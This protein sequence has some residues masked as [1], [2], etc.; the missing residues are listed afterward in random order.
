MAPLGHRLEH[1][2]LDVLEREQVRRAPQVERQRALREAAEPALERADVRVVD[3]AV[4]DVGDGVARR[5][6]GAA[7]RPPAATAATSGPRAENS[8]VIS[9]SPTSWPSSTPSSTSPTGPCQPRRPDAGTSVDGLDAARRSTRPCCDGRSAR[10]RRR[11]RP[12][13]RPRSARGR[14]RRDRR[15]RGPR[16][17]CGRAPGSAGRVEPALGVERELGVDRE[18]GGEREAARP[19]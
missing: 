4:A 10:P 15:G 16:R 7:R 8:V 6:P 1:A 12:R 19:R 3:V 2:A 13:P 9:S 14:R 18:P 17:R 11:C 5:R